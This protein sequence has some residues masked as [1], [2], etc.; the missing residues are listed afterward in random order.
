MTTNDVADFLRNANDDTLAADQSARVIEQTPHSRRNVIDLSNTQIQA[1]LKLDI[2]YPRFLCFMLTRSPDGRGTRPMDGHCDV[3]GNRLLVQPVSGHLSKVI[4]EEDAKEFER[5]RA[6]HLQGKL[7]TAPPAAP[8]MPASAASTEPVTA[9][10]SWI[11]TMWEGAR[12]NTA[13]PRGGTIAP[14]PAARSRAADQRGGIVARRVAEPLRRAPAGSRPPTGRMDARPVEPRATGRMDARLAR[15]QP[16]PP[17]QQ[18]Q[19]FA[20]RPPLA[21][22]RAPPRKAVR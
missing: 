18:Q 13:N 8:N 19:R 10:R 4:S 2:A 16:P 20:S 11:G 14:A 22:R 12:T 17:A 6:L 15:S 5:L 21:A 1:Y 9:P 7:G 3:I